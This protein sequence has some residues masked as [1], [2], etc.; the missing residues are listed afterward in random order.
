MLSTITFL[1]DF[2]VVGGYVAACE[3]VMARLAPSAR[4]LH[5]D[6][7]IAPGDVRD[8]ARV[9]SRLA[10]L[11]P[12][13]VHLAVVDPGVGGERLALALH[14]RRGD[15]LVG[16]D[17]GLLLPAAEALGGITAAWSLDAERVRRQ[18][19]LGETPFASR[20]FDGRDLFSPA[21]ALLTEELPGALLG[22]PLS[23]EDLVTV[24]PD[25]NDWVDERLATEVVE[26]DRFGN[27]ALA[28]RFEEVERRGLLES[29]S[30]ELRTA[31]GLGDCHTARR[32]DSFHELLA[33]E[34]G[35]L[36]DSWGRVALV[37][38]AEP[39]DEVLGVE[40]GVLLTLS[41]GPHMLPPLPEDEEVDRRRGLPEE[42]E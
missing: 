11:G 23:T 7:Q 28:A 35:V 17:N 16:P 42:W 32:V 4:I 25:R 36:S 15:F 22:E 13:A 39:A 41:R 29:G 6:H 1:S 21:A 37:L 10:P 34:L 24:E 38:N 30:L 19:E 40:A 2:G 18:A 12:T 14:T 9:L 3:L 26:V 31:G 8:G 20:T 33:G 27:V 5:L